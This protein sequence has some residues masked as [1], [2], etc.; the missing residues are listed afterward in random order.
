MPAREPGTRAQDRPFHVAGFLT[1][2]DSQGRRQS[3]PRQRQHRAS[4]QGGQE[5]QQAEASLRHRQAVKSTR[6]PSGLTHP[7]Q[8]P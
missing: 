6:A 2:E 7:L 3:R 8:S 5:H 4:G 1:Q